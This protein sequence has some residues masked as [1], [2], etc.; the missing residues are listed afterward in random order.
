MGLLKDEIALMT[1]RSRGID[2]DAAIARKGTRRS[3]LI[4]LDVRV[5][6]PDAWSRRQGP[7]T[8]P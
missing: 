7:A 8:V 2:V 1:G 3:G 5:P 4:S 6:D